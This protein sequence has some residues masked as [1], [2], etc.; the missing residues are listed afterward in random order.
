MKWVMNNL[1]KNYGLIKMLE[2]HSQT[3][4]VEIHVWIKYTL[5]TLKTEANNQLTSIHFQ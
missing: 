2:N 5:S 1:K 4:K 3:I